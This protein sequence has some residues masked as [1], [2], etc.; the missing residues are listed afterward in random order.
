MKLKA[1]GRNQIANFWLRQ[2][3]VTKKCLV[4][5]LDKFIDED[6]I[7]EWLTAEITSH[8]LKNENTD[9][10][11]TERPVTCPP[12]IY[13]TITSTIRKRMQKYTEGENGMP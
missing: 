5:L 9:R 3:T 12:T 2:F 6:R 10:P 1:P 4:T 11:K 8:I 7:L 13:E